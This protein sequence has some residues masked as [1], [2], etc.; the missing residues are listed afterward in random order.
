MIKINSVIEILKKVQKIK[1]E[2][3]KLK[4]KATLRKKRKKLK[5]NM[6]KNRI[7]KM[8]K[9]K[10]KKMWKKM[11]KKRKRRKKNKIINKIKTYTS[12]IKLNNE[13]YFNLFIFIYKKRRS[14]YVICF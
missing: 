13:Y 7:K 8:K 10:I 1:V 11:N 6:K 14:N 3:N 12:N 2:N 9:K 4:I 5:M